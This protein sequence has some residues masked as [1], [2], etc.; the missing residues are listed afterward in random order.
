M[1][2]WILSMKVFLVISAGVV[3]KISVPLNLNVNE[4][5]KIWSVILSWLKPP[6]LYIIINAIIITIAAASRFHQSDQHLI[7][8]KD[9]PPSDHFEP[10]VELKPVVKVNG[11]NLTEKE[12]VAAETRDLMIESTL[13]YNTTLQEIKSP[14]IH[15]L[16][17]SRRDNINIP[18]VSSSFGHQKPNRTIPQVPSGRALRVARSKR[19]ETLESTWKTITEGRHVPLT[20]HLKKSEHHMAPTVAHVPTSKDRTKYES[21]VN[22]QKQPSLGQDEL[23]RRVE[24]FIRKVNNDMRLQREESLNQYVQ[25]IN[26]GV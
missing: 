12:I 11:S 16:P 25:M 5:P 18:L 10:F 6:Y 24:A 26:H 2:N 13:E 7:S 17:R 4:I 14:E 21:G 22:I 8:I 1:S 3:I 15:P 9:P 19:Q 20:R 23:N